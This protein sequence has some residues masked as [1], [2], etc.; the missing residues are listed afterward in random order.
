MDNRSQGKGI[1]R[2][3]TMAVRAIMMGMEGAMEKVMLV[4]MVRTIT[5]RL[6]PNSKPRRQAQA[7]KT[8]QIINT[9]AIT[10][11]HTMNTKL[12]LAISR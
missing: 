11:P 1:P 4:F 10:I 2:T 9:A 7:K 5:S 12:L 8:Q 6:M 3:P